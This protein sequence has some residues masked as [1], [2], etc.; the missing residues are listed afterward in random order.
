MNCPLCQKMMTEKDLGAVLVDICESGCKGIWFD[1]LKLRKLDEKNEGFGGA[2]KETL[3]F[4][5]LNTDS[6][7][8][9]NC[10]KCNIPMHILRYPSQK[11]ITI[12]E[13]CPCGGFFLDSGEFKEIRDNFMTPE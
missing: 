13:C 4:P 9:I 5:R 1:W 8:K 2:L 3:L 12:D 6:R 7:G 10:P 11:E